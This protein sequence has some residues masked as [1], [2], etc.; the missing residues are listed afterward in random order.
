MWQR[1]KALLSASG[2]DT[3]PLWDAAWFAKNLYI[4]GLYAIGDKLS[5]RV[6]NELNSIGYSGN[7]C[8]GTCV[9]FNSFLIVYMQIMIIRKGLTLPTM[10]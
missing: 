8:L 3:T 4:S 6:I 5:S 1:P 9:K 10:F 7:L 2:C